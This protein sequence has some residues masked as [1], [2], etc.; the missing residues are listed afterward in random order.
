[1][2]TVLNG[3]TK[4]TDAEIEE[5]YRLAL[6]YAKRRA[7]RPDELTECAIDGATS[8][9][10][11]AIEHFDPTRGG[12]FMGFCASAVKRFVWRA[13]E[14]H[15]RR[16][17]NRPGTDG[18]PDDLAA[19]E[20]YGVGVIPIPSAVADL[21]TDLRDAVRFFYIDRF[22]LRECGLLLGVAPETVRQR[23]SHAAR[24]LGAG[25]IPRRRGTGEKRLKR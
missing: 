11:W 20:Q 6:A 9:V 13:T 3:E 24:I 18:L 14:L 21:P 10:M 23:L 1:M 2:P 7:P 25:L 4:P 16:Y 22:D 5:A 12:G 19:R 17:H 8:G 15:A